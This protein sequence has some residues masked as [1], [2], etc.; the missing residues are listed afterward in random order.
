MC[1]VVQV[2]DSCPCFTMIIS[3]QLESTDF[4]CGNAVGN[5]GGMMV[6]ELF[7]GYEQ[8]VRSPL[9]DVFDNDLCSSVVDRL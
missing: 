1:Q 6:K 8:T 5:P 3:F 7:L 4:I 9:T 2:N